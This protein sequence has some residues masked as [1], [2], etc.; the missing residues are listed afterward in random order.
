MDFNQLALE[1]IICKYSVQLLD[2]GHGHPIAD[3]HAG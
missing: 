1:N 2:L 3:G